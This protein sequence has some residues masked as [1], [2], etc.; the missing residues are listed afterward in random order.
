LRGPKDLQKVHKRCTVE[1]A[2]LFREIIPLMTTKAA[3]VANEERTSDEDGAWV[4][5]GGAALETSLAASLHNAIHA[6]EVAEVVHVPKP[7][8]HAS[9]FTMSETEKA[10]DINAGPETDLQS[11]T[12][13]QLCENDFSTDISELN[14][15][16]GFLGACL[17]DAETGL[18]ITSEGGGDTLDLEAA[19]AAHTEVVKAK[20]AAIEMLGHDQQI[21]DILITLGGQF[22]LIRP[23]TDTP[24]VFI[25][26]ALDE[27]NA[28]LNQARGQLR[29]VEKTV[30]L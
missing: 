30:S 19:G 14:K 16:D 26:A 20:L 28:D 15:I 11:A 22:H 18:M 1:T 23:L 13:T 8:T 25:F 3:A 9:P 6:R 12:S 21:D 27:Q 5:T 4:S 29:D 7:K 10:Q 24:T 17:V 2:E